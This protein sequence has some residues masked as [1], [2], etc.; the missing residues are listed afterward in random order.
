MA[1]LATTS[2]TKA[3]GSQKDKEMHKTTI[4]ERVSVSHYE[5]QH[6]SRDS[7]AQVEKRMST[8]EQR[9]QCTRREENVNI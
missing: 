3:D 7:N 5:W 4:N 6:L 2:K 9:Q 8:S 1:T